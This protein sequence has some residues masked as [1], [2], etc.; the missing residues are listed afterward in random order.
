[1]KRCEVWWANLPAPSGPRPVVLLS[2]DE[3]YIVRT[4][5]TVA[6]VTTRARGLRTEVPLGPAEGIPLPSV[7]NLDSINTIPKSLLS[8]QMG[9]LSTP[10]I[11]GVEAA[12]H[13]ALGL[14]T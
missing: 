6:P 4:H 3:A 10:K 14:E 9:S 1:M 5:V 2:R 7:A 13:F 11:H 12:V 8:R